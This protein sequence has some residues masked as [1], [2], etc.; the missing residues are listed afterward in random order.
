MTDSRLFQGSFV[1]AVNT[2]VFSV[3]VKGIL[4][5]QVKR[6]CYLH[7]LLRVIR[8]LMLLGNIISKVFYS[9]CS[10]R[11]LGKDDYGL[12]KYFVNMLTVFVC[13]VFFVCVQ[14]ILSDVIIAPTFCEQ[15]NS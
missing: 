12:C 8:A 7:Q 15:N 5:R 4:A 11:L 14:W 9:Y 2:V 6:R 1:T 10:N 13:F 3:S